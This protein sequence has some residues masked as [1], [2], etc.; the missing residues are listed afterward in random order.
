MSRKEIISCEKNLYVKHHALNNLADAAFC[1][2]CLG[3]VFH[4]TDDH[5]THIFQVIFSRKHYL[6]CSFH[7]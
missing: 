1:V 4:A 7:T 6:A 2:L 3:Y 5:I